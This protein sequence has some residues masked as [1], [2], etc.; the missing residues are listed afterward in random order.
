MANE[1]RTNAKDLT[2]V[3]DAIRSRTNNPD[4]LEFPYGFLASIFCIRADDNNIAR[5]V[6]S[7]LVAEVGYLEKAS[8]AQLDDKKANA[9]S[10]NYTKYARDLD[11][12]EGF[13]NG[14]KQGYD[15]CEVF[16]DWGFVEAYG[17]E[18]AKAL[19]C[20]PSESLGA[21]A[22]YSSQY[23]RNKGQFY[24][25][26]PKAG[27]QIFF[28]KSG[29]ETHTGLV[30]GVIGTTVYTVEGN[31]YSQTGVVE[32]GDGVYI[33]HYDITDERIV[34]YGRPKYDEVI[35][36]QGEQSKMPLD[37]VAW[38]GK[39]YRDIFLTGNKVTTGNAIT[40]TTNADWSSTVSKPKLTTKHF[41]TGPSSW[42]CSGTASIQMYKYIDGFTTS[43]MVYL[44]CKRK[45]VAYTAGSWL[46]F[47]A[48]DQNSNTAKVSTDV[49]AQNV[50]SKFE[51]VSGSYNVAGTQVTVYIGS[52]GGAKLTGYVDDIVCINMT[53]MFGTNIPT[54]AEMDKLY[55]N[56][57]LLYNIEN[58]K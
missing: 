18:N 8:N 35:P 1:Y 44:A 12:I 17:V 27:D 34:G 6:I 51:T 22:R 48:Y 37:Y 19:L 24:T 3:A 31:T 41:N 49:T 47:A 46:G 39:T 33:K 4:L 32:N 42:D 50:S 56:F 38:D 26:N 2:I 25:E 57:L 5:K 15:W 30:I 53:K 20:Q 28:G 23:Y 43:D 40:D 58:S 29:A 16:V 55:E 14:R 54:I 11:A 52:G 13:Y 7:I 36:E 21:S 9:G 10:N 45:L